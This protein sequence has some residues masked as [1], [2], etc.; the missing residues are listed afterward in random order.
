MEGLLDLRVHGQSDVMGAERRVVSVIYELVASFKAK[1]EVN[2][3]D[4]WFRV[5][6]LF[7]FLSLSLS[8]SQL[9]FWSADCRLPSFDLS[10][11]REICLSYRFSLLIES[12]WVFFV[13]YRESHRLFLIIFI[14]LI[15]FI[16]ISL[17]AD[18]MCRNSFFHFEESLCTVNI[19]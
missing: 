14:F 5:S 19:R 8:L 11:C 10:C 18:P 6:P 17:C 7:L 2:V 9:E 1:R 16:D 4:A 12:D 3:G 13:F 15:N